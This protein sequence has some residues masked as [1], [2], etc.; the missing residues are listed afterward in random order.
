MARPRNCK[1]CNKPKRP[2]GNKFKE[3]EGYCGCG[4]PPIIDKDKLNKLESAFSYG[5]SDEQACFIAGISPATL[6]NYQKANPEFLEKK[7]YLKSTPDIKAKKVVVD[8]LDM[9]ANAWRWLEKRDPDFKPV[10]KL[11][12]GG[13]VEISDPA[14]QMSEEEK[15]ALKALQQA[16]IK[17]MQATVVGVDELKNKQESEHEQSTGSTGRDS[18]I[19]GEATDL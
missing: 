19:S 4:R 14:G 12:L 15:E 1:K 7:R 2:Q 13:A 9:P 10:S 8:S 16:R 18:D 5:L 17:R 6:Y 11:E 3:L